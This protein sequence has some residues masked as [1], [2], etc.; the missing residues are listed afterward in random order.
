MLDAKHPKGT[1]CDFFAIKIEIC[2]QRSVFA[3]IPSQ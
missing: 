3:S 2:K 1:E